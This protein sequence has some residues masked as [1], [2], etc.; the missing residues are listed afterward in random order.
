M[1]IFKM[2]LVNLFLSECLMS[3]YTTA[4]ALHVLASQLPVIFGISVQIEPISAMFPGLMSFPR[5]CST[6]LIAVRVLNYVYV[7]LTP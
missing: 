6:V 4:T 1:G 5:V 7:P 2:G 3:G